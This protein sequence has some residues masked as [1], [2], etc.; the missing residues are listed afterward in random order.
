MARSD[1]INAE[2]SVPP[3]LTFSSLRVLHFTGHTQ[4][5]LGSGRRK[6]YRYRMGVQTENGD[7]EITLWRRL[8]RELIRENGEQALFYALEQ[9]VRSFAAWLRTDAEIEQYALE[10]HADRIF[11][12]PA[13][14]GYEEFNQHWRPVPPSDP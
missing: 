9:Y 3:R 10:L 2:D 12:D 1:L 7:I 8:V 11:D 13:W 4:P 5:V 14:A 6:E